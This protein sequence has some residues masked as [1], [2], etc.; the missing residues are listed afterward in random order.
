[1]GRKRVPGFEQQFGQQVVV[2]ASGDNVFD[3]QIKLS[4]ECFGVVR[5][6]A[7]PGFEIGTA[8]FEHLESAVLFGVKVIIYYE[9]QT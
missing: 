4:G 9:V 7:L 8:E 2:V 3:L 1:M 6:I 5:D